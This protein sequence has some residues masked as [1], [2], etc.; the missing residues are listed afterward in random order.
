MA[1]RWRRD[2]DAQQVKMGAAAWRK[3]VKGIRE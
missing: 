1:M 3:S 2:F